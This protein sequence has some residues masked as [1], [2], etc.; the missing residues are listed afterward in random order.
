MRSVW[1]GTYRVSSGRDIVM[2]AFS[3][4][5]E[6][7][8]LFHVILIDLEIYFHLSKNFVARILEFQ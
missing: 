3:A 4:G 2:L 5:A 6:G 1:R 8:G 7:S